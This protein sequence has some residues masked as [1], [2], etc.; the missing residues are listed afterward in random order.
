MSVDEM[1]GR[2]YGLALQKLFSLKNTSAFFVIASG[3]RLNFQQN[4]QRELVEH[5][6]AV[7]NSVVIDASPL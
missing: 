2:Q 3:M 1:A 4:E 6:T 5:F 7:L